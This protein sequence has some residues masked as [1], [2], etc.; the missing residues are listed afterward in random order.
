MCVIAAPV[1]L[2][3]YLLASFAVIAFEKSGHYIEAAAV[4][5][6][7]VL[8]MC[9]AF[10][11]PGHRRLRLAQEW[12][13]GNEVDRA[14]ALN[15]TYAY[16]R[17]PVTRLVAVHAVLSAVLLVVVGAIA[18]ASWSRLAQY[19]ILGGGVGIAVQLIAVHSVVEERCDPSGSR[20]LATRESV[21]PC[22]V[23]D[24]RLPLGRTFQC[25]WSRSRSP[26]AAR[27]WRPRLS[28]P[29]SSPCSGS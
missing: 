24:R 29:P 2:P 22:P 16:A 5:V 25:S 10:L 14:A 7:A 1:V 12:A 4:T 20:S 28:G 8:A 26:R 13:A 6:V 11:P 21:T 17:R 9:Y 15:D 23:H 18:G 3:I 27:C 19:A